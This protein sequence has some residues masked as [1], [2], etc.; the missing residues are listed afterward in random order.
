MHAL[1]TFNRICAHL[2]GMKVGHL[3]R[4]YGSAIFVEFGELSPGR[5]RL[6]GSAGNPI[7]EITLRIEW[8]WRIEDATSIIC[9]SWS[10]EELWEPSFDLV[11]GARVAKLSL[12]G[13][14]PEIDLAFSE[15][16]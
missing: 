1:S 5:I 16:R 9:G 13:R 12:F 11:R 6:D 4:G 14:L 7:G 3:W 10:E 15:D 2:V 8:S